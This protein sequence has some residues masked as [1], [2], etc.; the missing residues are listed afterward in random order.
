[1][2]IILGA[3]FLGISLTFDMKVVG[4]TTVQLLS[5]GCLLIGLGEYSNHPYDPTSRKMRISG[6]LFELIGFFILVKGIFTFLK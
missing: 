2:A 6:I 1:M 3:I 4:N 5:L